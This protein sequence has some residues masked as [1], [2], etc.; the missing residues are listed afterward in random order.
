MPSR[1]RSGLARTP[2]VLVMAVALY[3]ILRGAILL[4][5][6]DSVCIEVYELYPMGTLAQ[7]LREDSH[8]PLHIFYDNAAGQLLVGVL[9]VPFFALFGSTYLALKLLPAT[10]GLG[11]LLVVW[12]FCDRHFGRG[13]A[14]LA[15]LLFA[16]GPT[17]LVKYSL[18][19]SGNHFENV[20]FS[21][22]VLCAF[23]RLHTGG[24]RRLWL[25]ASGV[26]AG[27]ALFVFLGAILPVGLCVLAHV[28]VRGA[29]GTLRDLRLGL[30]ATL[31]GAAPLI[32]I[33]LP[34]GGR[35]FRFFEW[36]FEDEKGLPL[37][38]R[39]E[40]TWR[41]LGDFFTEHLVPA[42]QSPD[43]LGLDGRVL[44]GLYLLLF[45]VAWVSFLPDGL[46]GLRALLRGLFDWRPESARSQDA[47]QA[48]FGSFIMAPLVALLPLTGL[49]F[50][51]SDLKIGAGPYGQVLGFAGFRYFNWHFLVTTLLVAAAAGRWLRSPDRARRGL[52]WGLGGAALLLAA[53]NLTLPRWSGGAG[54]VGAHYEAYNYN[55]VARGLLLSP[56]YASYEEL[57][58]E[59]EAL[60]L[61]RQREVYVGIGYYKAYEAGLEVG[62]ES[63]APA[64]T[65]L[66][67][68]WP[69][70]HGV[71]L[72]RGIGR[73]LRSSCRRLSPEELPGALE[74]ALAGT[75]FRQSML[76]GLFEPWR[77]PLEGVVDSMLLENLRLYRTLLEKF[78][79]PIARGHG[80]FC[81][82]LLQRSVPADL[83]RVDALVRHLAPTQRGD[84]YFGLGYGAAAAQPANS[85]PPALLE[86]L[87][88]PEARRRALRGYGSALLY[89]DGEEAARAILTRLTGGL[90][91]A[92]AAAL[93]G[94]ASPSDPTR[95]D[96]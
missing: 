63:I 94:G 57:V 8:V 96:P 3:A 77:F 73:H 9:A 55:K 74:T 90:P 85:L 42:P 54:N 80:R 61:R 70:E 41:R 88:H 17:T 91:E 14:N 62:G 60:P 10:L 69:A 83:E 82:R 44:D 20:F 66:L 23:Y 33:N 47:E 79:P 37:A 29:R 24:N 5:D 15:A 48:A 78:G 71:D 95:D 7:V 30:P 59:I 76:E 4:T 2:W 40:A 46:R 72:A 32:A 28:A 64:A 25:I 13:S 86:R 67:A 53:T 39:L 34:T 1:L 38:E 45:L 50:A 19:A 52:G 21:S 51:I 81:G 6:F 65:R 22:L 87:Q 18:V 43:I 49:A 27:F 16:L 56:L 93:W 31:V 89:L 58:P 26:A 36:R 84:F 12:R 68:E 92:D 35:V 75:S 11:V